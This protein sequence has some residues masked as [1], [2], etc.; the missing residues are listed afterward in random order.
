MASFFTQKSIAQE[1][2]T[3]EGFQKFK[4]YLAEQKNPGLIV[5][6]SKPSLEIIVR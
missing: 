1:R 2:T 4:G 6:V 3:G 5:I